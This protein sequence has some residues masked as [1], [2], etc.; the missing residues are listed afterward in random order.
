MKRRT[1]D[2]VNNWRWPMNR[3]GATQSSEQRNNRVTI[4]TATIFIYYILFNN[5]YFMYFFMYYITIKI[6]LPVSGLGIIRIFNLICII[7]VFYACTFWSPG[8]LFTRLGIDLFSPPNPFYRYFRSRGIDLLV[9]RTSL[10]GTESHVPPA[11]RSHVP[12][13]I[14]VAKKDSY[15]VAWLRRTK[16]G[17]ARSRWTRMVNLYLYGQDGFKM[18]L[19]VIG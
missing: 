19:Q 2:K 9:P 11:P 18:N 8:N 3:V 12:R 10:G 4:H 14:W 7:I 17:I 15:E 6:A 1:V 5:I 13:W 16:D